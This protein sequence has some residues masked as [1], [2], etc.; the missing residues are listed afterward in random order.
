MEGQT[1][2]VFLFLVL[3]GAM[4][5][6]AIVLLFLQARLLGRMNE[7]MVADDIRSE[8]TPSD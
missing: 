1:T 3:V 4:D 2:L 8:C 7:K 5:L 6:I